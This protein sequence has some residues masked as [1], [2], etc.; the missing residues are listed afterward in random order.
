M[1][2]IYASDR[3]LRKKAF[4]AF[5]MVLADIPANPRFDILVALIKNSD[6]SSM[7]AILL[8]CVREEMHKENRERVSNGNGVSEAKYIAS[9]STVFWSPGVLELVEFILRP[10]EGGPPILPEYSD[11]AL[12]SLNLY[13]Y[14]LITESTGKTNYTGALSKEN[15][16]KSYREWLLP[17]RILVTGI[18]AES[19]KDHDHL[20]GFESVCALNPVELV[21]YHCI[22]LVEE[23]M[24]K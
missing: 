13:R 5:K 19:K 16:Q 8:D 17:L 22:E 3:V 15:L 21:L 24:K 23:N 1:V 2:I 4:D 10:P 11:A 14:I 12:S 6:S 18:V 20:G 7:I 9:Q